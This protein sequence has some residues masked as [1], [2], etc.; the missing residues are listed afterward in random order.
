MRFPAYGGK[1]REFLTPAVAGELFF[2]ALA[3]RRRETLFVFAFSPPSAGKSA[4]VFN[5]RR[6]LQLFFTRSPAVGGR[7][8]DCYPAVMFGINA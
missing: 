7:S 3:R 6:G 4:G 5:P 8:A 1:A 2:C